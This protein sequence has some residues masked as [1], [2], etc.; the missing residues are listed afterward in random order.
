MLVLTRKKNQSFVILLPSGEQV[1]VKVCSIDG[2]ETRIG[3]DAPKHIKIHR[4]EIWAALAPI[5]QANA[6][7][8]NQGV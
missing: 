4:S 5:P 6:T 7:V 2:N 3:I 8:P 1:I